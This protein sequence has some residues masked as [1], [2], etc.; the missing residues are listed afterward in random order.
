MTTSEYRE[1]ILDRVGLCIVLGR[2]LDKALDKYS[3][4]IGDEEPSEKLRSLL[5]AL[6]SCWSMARIERVEGVEPCTKPLLGT[7]GT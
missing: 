4:V 5:Q 3:T 1:E 2:D 6:E 7:T